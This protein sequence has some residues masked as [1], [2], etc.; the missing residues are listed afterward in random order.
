MLLYSQFS[1]KPKTVLK[2]NLLENK[3]SDRILLVY[4]INF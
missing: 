2:N 3:V 4:P 1:C